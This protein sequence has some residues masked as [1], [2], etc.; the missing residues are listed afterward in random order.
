MA[1]VY[2]RASARRDLVEDYVYL[3]EHAGIETA[4][5]FLSSADESF[6]DLARHPGMGTAVRSRSEVDRVAQVADQRV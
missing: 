5:R 6:G 1:T 3:A 4:E 2:K